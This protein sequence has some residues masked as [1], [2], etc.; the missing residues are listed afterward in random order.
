MLE[1]V[2]GFFFVVVCVRVRHN[3]GH[4]C[5]C[6]SLLDA[7]AKFRG[8]GTYQLSRMLHAVF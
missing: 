8:R 1:L 4:N 2:F 3:K 5:H 6:S 7:T